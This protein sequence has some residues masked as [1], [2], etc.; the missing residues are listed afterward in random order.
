MSNDDNQLSSTLVIE[1]TSDTHA[2]LVVDD[3]ESV[4]HFLVDA[5]ELKKYKVDS[6]STI[7]E[8][9]EKLKS[10][11]ID[12]IV[13]DINF[14]EE[15]YT[16]IDFFRFCKEHN[17]NIPF[18]LVTGAPQLEDAVAI[19]KEGASD[20]ISKPIQI[21]KLYERID[22]AID[23][24]S[25]PKVDP[26]IASVVS[27]IPPE[28]KIIR[29]IDKTQTSVVLLVEKE[30]TYYAMKIMKFEY[31]DNL[32]RKKVDRF[33]RE[34][35]IMRS[36]KHPN[37]VRVFEYRFVDDEVPFIVSEYVS[38]SGL[39][40]EFIKKLDFK[41]K[42]SLIKKVASAMWEVHKHGIIHRDI[43]PANILMTG[44][45]EPKLTDFG[46]ARVKDSSLTMTRELLGSPNYMSPE[47]FVSSRDLDS[48]SDIFSFGV[49]AYYILTEKRPF[50]GKNINQI[51]HE[52]QTHKPIRPSELNHEISTKLDFIL[53][54]LLEK[55]PEKR[56][57]NIAEFITQIDY[58]E[59][60]AEIDQPGL[61]SSFFGKSK[62][63]KH[64][65]WQ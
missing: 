63:I 22:E 13:S 20:Y 45:G 3:D 2:I 60:G 29:L 21:G 14:P 47:A 57:Q 44:E 39:S 8:A 25:S 5:L 32:N 17:P 61:L 30:K 19:L 40:E 59:K 55:D 15:D 54:G 46:I 4:R 41:E 9:L 51:M 18:I 16:G 7:Q 28:Y 56:F 36:I 38:G 26:V 33:F 64:D 23:K 6:T 48:R 65:V 12:I 43:K 11:K 58:Y 24:L 31:M 35:K 62:K 34:A 10:D 50:V 53:A 52:I 49:V 1:K 27:H 37:V 42:V